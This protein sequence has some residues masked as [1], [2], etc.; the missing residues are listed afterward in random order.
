M[1]K[2]MLPSQLYEIASCTHSVRKR[3][4][5][6][7]DRRKKEE[8]EEEDKEEERGSRK[9][10]NRREK[11]ENAIEAETK[12]GPKIREVELKEEAD[13]KAALTTLAQA[14]MNP[15]KATIRCFFQEEQIFDMDKK[16]ET[17]GDKRELIINWEY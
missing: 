3:T 10:Q 14:S 2:R 8:E 5:A 15:H 11:E 1:L 9:R 12:L 16:Y 7:G 6:G 17:T 4:K 13:V